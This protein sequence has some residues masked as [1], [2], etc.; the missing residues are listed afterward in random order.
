M[1]DFPGDCTPASPSGE[2][3]SFHTSDA[4]VRNSS[5]WRRRHLRG[6]RLASVSFRRKSFDSNNIP[7]LFV[8]FLCGRRRRMFQG[9]LASPSTPPVLLSSFRHFGRRS[10]GPPFVFR[11]SSSSANCATCRNFASEQFE[12]GRGT[13]PAECPDRENEYRLP[14][15]TLGGDSEKWISGRRGD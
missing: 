13:W 15:T 5:N 12:Q 1:R 14:A 8:T 11:R 9:S 2:V 7:G 3:H 4:Q 10:V 6:T